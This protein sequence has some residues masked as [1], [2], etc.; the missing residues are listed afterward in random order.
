MN[1]WPCSSPRRHQCRDGT[2]SYYAK[3][4]A[5]T[6]DPCLYWFHWF[7]E[8]VSTPT[9]RGKRRLWR[10]YEVTRALTGFGARFQ[11][12]PCRFRMTLDRVTTEEELLQAFRDMSGRE[13][14]AH[15]Q[16]RWGTLRGAGPLCS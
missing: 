15:T 2:F 11:N 4:D 9:H 3:G 1:R 7:D 16:I 8:T 10:Y 13:L 5:N 14:L 6:C 12:N